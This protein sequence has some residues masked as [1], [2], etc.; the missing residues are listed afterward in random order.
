[1]VGGKGYTVS[2]GTVLSKG[3]AQAQGGRVCLGPVEGMSTGIP[4]SRSAGGAGS[5]DA[6]S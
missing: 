2:R 5:L 3:V 1:M 4:G 6:E